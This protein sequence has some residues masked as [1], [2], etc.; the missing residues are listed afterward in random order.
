[1]QQ[2]CVHLRSYAVNI[3][4]KLRL[5]R[6]PI[7]APDSIKFL[8]Q[9]LYEFVLSSLFMFH[10][11]LRSLCAG[12]KKYSDAAWNTDDADWT[13]FHGYEIRAHPCYQ[14]N[15]CSTTT[16]SLVSINFSSWLTLRLINQG[17]AL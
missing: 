3:S 2:I 6:L 12:M 9:S 15:P 10:N 7:G 14:C 8:S 5:S 17:V 13:D 1:M 16:F 11:A 4:D